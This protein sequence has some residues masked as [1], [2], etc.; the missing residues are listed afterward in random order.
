MIPYLTL[1]FG[2]DIFKF[3]EIVRGLALGITTTGTI[4]QWKSGL[5]YISGSVYTLDKN[6]LD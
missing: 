3:T 6:K 1:G 4:T 5:K 2:N